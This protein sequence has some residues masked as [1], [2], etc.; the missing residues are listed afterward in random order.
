MHKLHDDFRQFFILSFCIA[1]SIFIIAM[2]FNAHMQGMILDPINDLVSAMVHVSKSQNYTIRVRKQGNDELGKVVDGFNDMLETIEE[3]Q[4]LLDKTLKAESEAKKQAMEANES[5]SRF[6]AN[7]SHEIRTPMNGVLGMIQVLQKTNLTNQQYRYTE[8]IRLSGENLLSLIN[9][10]LDFSKIE[11]DKMKLVLDKIDPYHLFAEIHDM[12]EVQAKDK[13]LALS[14]IL[15]T[16]IPTPLVGDTDRI[17]QIM[18]NLVG[19]GI[20]FTKTGYVMV[21]VTM[22]Q[23]SAH[24]I[25]LGIEV[26]DTGIGIPQKVQSHIFNSFVQADDSTTRN[27][28]GTGLG[29]A[30]TKQ[31]VSMMHGDIDIASEPGKGSTFTVSILLGR[32]RDTAAFPVTFARPATP[33]SNVQA[34]QSACTQN[35]QQIKV[36]IAEDNEVNQE[37]LV[38]VLKFMGCS[39]TLAVNGEKAVYLASRE[40]FDLILMDCQ[41]PVMDGFEA[42]RRIRA[43]KD[44]ILASVPIVA[45]TALAQAKDR[46]ACLDAGMNDYQSK[47]FSMDKLEACIAKWTGNKQ[48]ENESRDQ[49]AGRRIQDVSPGRRGHPSVSMSSMK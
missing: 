39:V 41:M 34:A 5:K 11:A 32:A 38:D 18:I 19:N 37:V 28:G 6:L 30:V 43:F 48:E 25:T 17:R 31:L 21:K 29:L 22:Q 2:I 27:F 35:H 20:K 47:P 16:D 7:M 44:P 15:C 1:I 40:R 33:P 4:T 14:T 12:M 24:G 45:M 26:K 8:L 36:L 42:T 46:Q 3:N 10:L 23:S 9:D 49:K 13:G